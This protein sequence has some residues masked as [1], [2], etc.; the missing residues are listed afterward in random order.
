[1]K[2][3]EPLRKTSGQNPIYPDRDIALRFIVSRIFGWSL[4]FWLGVG[5]ATAQLSSDPIAVSLEQTEQG[6]R[7]VRQ[8]ETYWIKGGGGEGPLDLLQQLGGNSTR[9]W[10]IE[11][12][13]P[14]RLDEAH[15]LG[16]TVALGIWLEH[17]R[18]GFRYTDQ[19]QV[20]QQFRTVLEHVRRF[21]DHPAVLLWGI[22]N[23]M[24]GDGSNLRIWQHVEKL[25]A[26]IKA[27][28]PHHPT[29]TVIAEMG[30]DKIPR[31]HALCPSIDIVG[32]NSYGG[33]LSVPQRYRELGGSKPYIVTEFGPPGPWE[34]GRN[35]T[36]GVLEKNSAAKGDDYRQ[37]YRAYQ[38]DQQL[39]LG[40]YAFLWGAKQEATA[41]W[42]GLLLSD[43]N[44]TAGVDELIP[45]WSGKQVANLC[46]KIEGL[47]LDGPD[48]VEPGTI[49]HLKL[50]T[51]DPENDELSV[52]WILMNEADS[53][54]TGG[55]FQ[56]TP[57]SHPANVLAA[58]LEKGLIKL[59]AEEGLYRIYVI[60][61]DGQGGA[62]TAN[63]PVRVR[64]GARTGMAAA[65]I[66]VELPYVLY[67]EPA[68]DEQVERF[69][70]SGWMGNAT[71]ISMNP[72]S[73]QQPK[74]GDHC[75]EIQYQSTT[76]WGGVV[77]QH[78]ANDWG[79]QPGGMD[80][81]GASKLTFWA[82]GK[83]GGEKLTFGLGVI[84]AEKRFPDSG[85]KELNVELTPH[86]REYS[87][88]LSDI[89][90]RQIKTGF[91]WSAAGQAEPLTFYLDRIVYSE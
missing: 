34:S 27:M 7:L 46:P 54:E 22:G 73:R 20:D 67:D 51:S 32:I 65:E 39:C 82:R 18:H 23:E 36:G 3:I 37:A 70:P 88:D 53:Y 79:D 5:T 83:T 11:E 45:L 61:R 71:A 80:L 74:F 21:K 78:P 42:F 68:D 24:E 77:W 58:D 66:K 64:T 19:E 81:R 13:T 12:T 57:R 55:D 8:G 6:W 17:E 14:S 47:E 28:D 63:L 43:G 41:T 38:A 26:E 33:A 30:G 59:P 72:A 10:G 86:W 16:L 91:F 69:H 31:L 50:K 2:N 52:S 15:Q 25:A 56:A 48:I 35:A 85:R 40:C 29:M 1:M 84:G 75:L 60:L 76:E 49:V 89:D 90:L 4:L 62:A 44:K 9:I 87:L